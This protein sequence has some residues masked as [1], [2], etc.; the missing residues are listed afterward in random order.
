MPPSALEEEDEQQDTI[1][2]Q[3]VPSDQDQT[4]GLKKQ[5]LQK[6][7]MRPP[8][9]SPSSLSSNIDPIT[10]NLLGQVNYTRQLE[11]PEPEEEQKMTTQQTETT[12]FT[13]SAAQQHH[14]LQQ[15]QQQPPQQYERPSYL[16][17]IQP[18]HPQ[19][20]TMEER[21]QMMPERREMPWRPG[22]EPGSE[23]ETGG[24]SR[25]K[26]IRFGCLLATRGDIAPSPCNSCAN[27]RGKF[28]VCVYLE[29]FFKGACASCQLSGRPN[30]CSIKVD[31]GMSLHLLA[32]SKKTTNNQAEGKQ[33]LSSPGLA[34][35]PEGGTSTTSAA[36]SERA[37][38]TG[39]MPSPQSTSNEGLPPIINTIT[40]APETRI[41]A[42]AA[43]ISRPPS[44]GLF[45]GAP[46]LKRR[47]I[48]EPHSAH[49]QFDMDRP[50]WQQELGISQARQ[51]IGLQRPWPPPGMQKPFPGPIQGQLPPH[52]LPNGAGGPRGGPPGPPFGRGG[53][54]RAWQSVNQSLPPGALG[55]GARGRMSP[56][57]EEQQQGGKGEEGEFGGGEGKSLIEMMGKG[58][59]RQIYGLVSGL[60]GGIDHLQR[61]LDGLKRAIGID[62]A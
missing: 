45:Q 7:W 57:V 34:Q 22:I 27:G 55:P 35:T 50:Q 2:V 15:Q 11:S 9:S 46:P 37:V 13:A 52:M 12:T 53:S 42:L 4:P 39:M 33:E 18:R 60:Q 6:R 62:D 29:G 43:T 31:D 38:P 58:R 25:R 36:P 8:P 20:L 16:N 54:P 24:D 49:P 3:D 14:Q 23:Y 21:L 1:V 30:R 17:Q 32:V 59:Q 28:S 51:Q 61:E 40:S 56:S 48:D 41:P 10:A 44:G 5:E 26:Q 47:R 19:G